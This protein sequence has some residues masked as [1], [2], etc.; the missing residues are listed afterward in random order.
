MIGGPKLPPDL[1]PLAAE[2]FRRARRA[3][4]D[5]KLRQRALARAAGDAA[6]DAAGSRARP[7]DLLRTVAWTVGSAVVGILGVTVGELLALGALVMLASVLATG[8]VVGAAHGAS[9]RSLGLWPA[10][11]LA[12]GTASVGPVYLLLGRIPF[13]G[14]G[15]FVAAGILAAVALAGYALGRWRTRT[16]A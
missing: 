13:L 11:G 16:R 12:I 8:V 7:T 4:Y 10:V 15:W 2:D 6:G 5:R 9:G 14:D 1:N 3:D